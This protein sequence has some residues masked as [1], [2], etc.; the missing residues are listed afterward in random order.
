MFAVFGTLRLIE[1]KQMGIGLATAILID[2]TIIRGVLLPATL[3]LL[4]PRAWYLPR[5]LRRLPNFGIESRR[6]LE[7]D[8]VPTLGNV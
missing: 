4:G 7:R 6:H 1:F 5:W 2:A 3:A 8:E